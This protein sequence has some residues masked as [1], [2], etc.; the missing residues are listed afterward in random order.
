LQQRK[1]RAEDIYEEHLK[2]SA[3]LPVNVDSTAVK[4]VEAN[5]QDPSTELFSPLQYQVNSFSKHNPYSK[6]QIFTSLIY[7]RFTP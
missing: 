7:C 4:D 3:S 6:F 1:K 2:P 5:L